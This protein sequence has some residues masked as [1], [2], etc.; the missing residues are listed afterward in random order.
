VIAEPLGGFFELAYPL[1]SAFGMAV[2]RALGMVMITPSFNRLGLTG[3]IRSAVAVVVSIPIAPEVFS[4][5]SGDLAP[6]TLM[7]MALLVKEVIIGLVIGLI[8]GI[9]FWAAEVAGELIDLQRGSTMAQLLDPSSAGESSVTSTLLSITLVTLF[10]MSGG[11]TLMLDGLYRSYHLWPVLMTGP[12]LGE[13]TI[14][15]ILAVLDKVMQIG[16][17]M[18]AP[19]VIALLTAD[20]LLAYLARM[21]PQLHV[22]DLSLSL[23][24]LLFSFLMVVY[25]GF[26]IP[27]M[28]SQLGEMRGWFDSLEATVRTIAQRGAP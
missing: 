13:A 11:F 7:L 16:V 18:I 9:P 26:L 2:A 21:A 1:L 19:V 8:F 5:L 28:L 20:L 15:E 22:F 12:A 23:K 27:Y 14:L 4:T 3:M 10:F 24:N 17:L 25:V 6:S